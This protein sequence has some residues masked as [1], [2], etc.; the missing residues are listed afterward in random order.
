MYEKCPM[1]NNETCEFSATYIGDKYCGIGEKGGK[2]NSQQIITKIKKM[3]ECPLK[4][5]A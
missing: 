1:N 4:K 3:K 5:K 2:G